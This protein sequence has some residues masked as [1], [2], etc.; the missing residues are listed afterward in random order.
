MS[1]FNTLNPKAEHKNFEFRVKE[2]IV[3][4]KLNE[5]EL[6]KKL[7]LKSKN[8]VLLNCAVYTSTINNNQ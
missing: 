3:I 4:Y 6:S 7:D 5:N 2:N 1:E 8:I